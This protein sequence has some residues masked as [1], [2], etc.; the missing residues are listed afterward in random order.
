MPIEVTPTLNI[1]YE[2]GGP[3]NGFPVIFYTVG[4]TMFAPTIGWCPSSM[5]QDLALLCR[6]CEGSAIRPLYPRRQ[7]VLVK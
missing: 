3:S 4:P 7:C 1:A 6:I 2:A 5:P